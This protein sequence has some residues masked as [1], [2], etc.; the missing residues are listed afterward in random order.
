MPIITHAYFVA[1]F[2]EDEDEETA[3]PKYPAYL[4]HRDRH[5]FRVLTSGEVPLEPA[6]AAPSPADLEKVAAIAAIVGT[7]PA[8]AAATLAACEAL[9]GKIA[10]SE[11]AALRQ[12]S[13]RERAMLAS[14]RF[15]SAAVYLA[16][17]RANGGAR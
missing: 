8:D 6:P 1:L 9:M 7:N 2:H 15:P 3:M 4:N 10:N 14:S 12:L 11:A 17:K 5:T 16:R 13:E